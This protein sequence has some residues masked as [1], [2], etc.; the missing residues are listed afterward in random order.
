MLSLM[1]IRVYAFLFSAHF[2]VSTPLIFV[3]PFSFAKHD[4]AFTC[5]DTIIQSPRKSWK[6]YFYVN[7]PPYCSSIPSRTHVLNYMSLWYVGDIPCLSGDILKGPSPHLEG[8]RWNMKIRWL[9][10]CHTASHQLPWREREPLSLSIQTSQ[11]FSVCVLNFINILK[12]CLNSETP[13][14]HNWERE[15]ASP[16]FVLSQNYP[17]FFWTFN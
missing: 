10:H 11:A 1:D 4:F 16:T 15:R 17:W 9:M 3:S 13:H 8:G 7:F 6:A 12:I 5:A 14:T 2:L